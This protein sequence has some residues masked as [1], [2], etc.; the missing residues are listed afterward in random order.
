[1]FQVLKSLGSIASENFSIVLSL[2]YSLLQLLFSGGTTLF[3]MVRQHNG[4]SQ[5]EREGE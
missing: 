1:M 5:R 4:I 3:N 2:L